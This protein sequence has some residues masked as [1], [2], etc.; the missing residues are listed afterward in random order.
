VKAP[1]EVPSEAPTLRDL[2]ALAWSL[3]LEADVDDP[4]PGAPPVSEDG[5]RRT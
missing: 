5:G 2:S 4:V 3:D 1:E